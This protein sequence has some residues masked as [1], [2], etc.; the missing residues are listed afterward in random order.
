V[1][2]C[3][4]KPKGLKL[5]EE[6]FRSAEW[7]F[8]WG[9]GLYEQ[10]IIQRGIKASN[11]QTGPHKVKICASNEIISQTKIY[12]KGWE[13]ILASCTSEKWLIP[14][15]QTEVITKKQTRG[16]MAQMKPDKVSIEKNQKD[17]IKMA[18]KYWRK[19]SKFL[20]GRELNY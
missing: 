7:R 9:K 19:C 16:L 11:W 2:D 13:I 6:D 20:E 4:V 18:S 12:P 17:Q 15:I 5:L 1:K 8:K 10:D 14:R 3:H